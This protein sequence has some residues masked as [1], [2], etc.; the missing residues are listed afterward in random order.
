MTTA[1]AETV[2]EWLNHQSLSTKFYHPKMSINE[3]N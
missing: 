3:R 2:S 1:K